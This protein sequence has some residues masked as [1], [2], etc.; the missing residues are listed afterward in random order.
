MVG[1]LSQ[2]RQENTLAS[3]RHPQEQSPG[4]L[5]TN[6]HIVLYTEAASR[7]ASFADAATLLDAALAEGGRSPFLWLDLLR[8]THEQLTEIAGHFDLHPLAVED[9]L[10][11]NQRPKYEH[12]GDTDLLVLRPATAASG[13]ETSHEGVESGQR[14]TN[15]G[16]AL[17]DVRVGELHVFVGASFIIVISHSDIVDL[18][19]VREEFERDS[20]FTKRPQFS[21]LY[22]IMDAVVDGYEPLLSA[23]ED[24]TDILE[25]RIFESGP[26]ASQLVYSLS[27]ELIELDHAI[28][29]LGALVTS[30][31]ASLLK[32]DLPDELL[33]GLR[34]VTDHIQIAVERMERLRRVVRE[35]FSVNTTLI[36]ERQNEDM[37]AMNELS[38][39]QNDQMKKISAWAG[40]F[41]F[42]SLVA[43][44]YGMNFAQMPELHWALGYPFA[45]GL[46]LT[47]SVALYLVFKR[48]GWL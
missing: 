24:Y 26:V 20:H 7:P 14:G 25:A 6:S 48:V 19:A 44:N 46:M 37:R 13:R 41:F 22:R 1:T 38:I 18:T 29:P 10:E 34:D 4:P 9:V 35:I 42:P 33:R 31:H 8:P 15:G 45:I 39:Q 2:S 21:A 40:I 32:H 16:G 47:G 11:A 5:G 30:L 43:S 23:L 28:N 17:I 27:R 36:A 12:Y 3:P